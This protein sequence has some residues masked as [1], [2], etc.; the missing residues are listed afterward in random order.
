M[1]GSAPLYSV[2]NEPDWE[3]PSLMAYVVV[4]LFFSIAVTKVLELPL[5]LVSEP[6]PPAN[7]P[8]SRSPWTQ[9]PGPEH[10]GNQHSVPKLT[11]SMWPL[12]V[13]RL[14]VSALP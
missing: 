10:G 11:A 14:L 8:C 2:I 12:P 6:L 9:G 1:L 13:S 7:R 5:L 3:L 4:P